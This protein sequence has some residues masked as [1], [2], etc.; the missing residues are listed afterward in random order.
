MLHRIATLPSSCYTTG[1]RSLCVLI[2]AQSWGRPA[3]S[4]RPSDRD[5]RFIDS[6]RFEGRVT[7]A[8]VTGSVAGSI[9]SE[10]MPAL[11]NRRPT[12]L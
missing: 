1:K 5:D 3:R 2:S 9:S 4:G 6:L 8:D 10:R 12:L 7:D 11:A